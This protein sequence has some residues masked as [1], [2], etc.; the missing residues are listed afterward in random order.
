MPKNDAT[1]RA[2]GLSTRTSSLRVEAAP[3]PCNAPAVLG[4][5]SLSHGADAGSWKCWEHTD[6]S[7]EQG[8]DNGSTC[9]SPPLTAAQSS[10][11][12]TVV[13]CPVTASSRCWPATVYVQKQRKETIGGTAGQA[14]DPVAGI[15]SETNECSSFF[16]TTHSKCQSPGPA[17]PLHLP[18]Q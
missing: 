5:G 13:L 11:H 6:R 10:L 4:K 18:F 7:E 8:Q 16:S 3:Q 14:T 9:Y 1:Q 17:F 12:T 15:G 2:R